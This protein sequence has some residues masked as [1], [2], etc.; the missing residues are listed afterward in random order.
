M[1]KHMTTP[2]IN[3]LIVH[4][5]S[6]LYGSDVTLLNFLKSTNN[7]NFSYT[8]VVPDQ[9][10]L[11]VELSKIA[12]VKT[13]INKPLKVRRA[14]FSLNGLIG[15]VKRIQRTLNYYRTIKISDY[16]V[17]YSNTLAIIDGMLLKIFFRK[18]HI[19]HVHEIIQSPRL[20]NYLFRLALTLFSDT[21]IY[22]SNTT[23]KAMSLLPFTSTKKKVVLNGTPDIVDSLTA[24]EDSIVDS[25]KIR[26]SLIGRISELKGQELLIDAAAKLSSFA[27]NKVHFLFIGTPVPG[28]ESRVERLKNKI[29]GLSLSEFFTFTGFIEHKS[30]IWANTDITVLPSIYPESFGMVVIESWAAEKPV[31]AS[32]HGGPSEIIS[33]GETGLL[34]TPNNSESL[35]ATLERLIMDEK[36]LIHL[37][38]TARKVFLTA[39]SSDSYAQNIETAITDTLSF[40]KKSASK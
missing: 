2:S 30:K 36:L 32:D 29:E 3:I 10:P 13:I 22:N 9:G 19:W 15:V 38:Q 34:F 31:I 26:V 23:A 17:V 5:S 35:A 14:D 4:Q 40:K 12:G 1:R 20:A 39:F 6:E 27:L 25:D 37:Q 8:V 7:T 16:D 11:V 33:N 28:D 24:D 18:K 21:V